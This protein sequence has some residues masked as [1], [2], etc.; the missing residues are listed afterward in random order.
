MGIWRYVPFLLVLLGFTSKVEAVDQPIL[1]GMIQRGSSVS[2]FTLTVKIGSVEKFGLQSGE[3]D[4]FRNRIRVYINGKSDAVPIQGDPPLAAMPFYVSQSNELQITNH[5]SNANLRDFTYTLLISANSYSDF[6]TFLDENGGK[7]LKLTVKY[8]E[9]T[10]EV[11]KKENEVISISSAV[12]SSAPESVIAKGTHR[13]LVLGWSTSATVTWSGTTPSTKPSNITLIAIDKSATLTSLPAYIYNETADSDSEAAD[14]TCSFSSGFGDGAACV[15]CSNSKAYLNTEEL[16]NLSTSGVYIAQA[17]ADSGLASISGLDNGKS[18]A[19]FAYYEPGG[20]NRSACVSASPQANTTYSELNG[21]D[22]ATLSDPKCFIAT[23]AY[24]SSLHKNLKPLR[25]FRDHVLSTFEIGRNFIDWYYENGPV[26]ATYV[27]N[28]AVLQ[29]L[30]QGA[31]WIPVFL[32]S[33]WMAFANS[34]VAFPE[35]SL[36]IVTCIAAAI[37]GSMLLRRTRGDR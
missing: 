30:V 4:L 5:A 7:S 36:L 22:D 19:V 21:E 8:L 10:T 29:T 17:S 37:A 3:T 25:W 32:L 20:L 12:V 27:S 24:G 28:S 26:A 11:T 34:M 16:Q 6:K 35:N 33:L 23:A 13:E 31:L 15:T 18:Y 1:S 9:G 2:S 14:G